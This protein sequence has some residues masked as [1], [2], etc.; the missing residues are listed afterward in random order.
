MRERWL[1]KLAIVNSAALFLAGAVFAWGDWRTFFAHP[2]R[3]GVVLVSI[4]ATA[5]TLATEV[6]VSAG[7]REGRSDR[8]AMAAFVPFSLA[9]ALL[10]PYM[11][12]RDMWVVGG[13][14][15]RYLGHRRLP[16][17]RRG[18]VGHIAG[19]RAARIIGP[20]LAGS[21]AASD[22]EHQKNPSKYFH[23]RLSLIRN[24]LAISSSR[25]R[26]S[27]KKRRPRVRLTQDVG[28]TPDRKWP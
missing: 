3:T 11:E 8:W 18:H 10:P 5:A 6:N 19:V 2:A 4:L 21:D 14:G 15:V 24:C 9:I 16:G 13:D 28:V 17:L 12:R 25:L 7:R 26:L 23:Y 1:L 20:L 27:D 22:Y